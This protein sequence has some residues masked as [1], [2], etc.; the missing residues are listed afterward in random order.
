MTSETTEYK[1]SAESELR[2][3]VEEETVVCELKS[4]LAEMFGTEL[5]KGHKYSFRSGSKVAVFTYHGCVVDLTG[6]PEVAYVSKE[7]PMTFYV[8]L[9]AALEQL[10]ARAQEEDRRGPV[11]MIV[12]PSDCGKSTLCRILLNYA[13]RMGRSPMF[14]DLDVGQGSVSIAGTIGAVTVERPADIEDGF[15]LVAP[16]VYHFG[17]SSPGEN[18]TLY[19]ILIKT[20]SESVGLKLETEKKTKYS[21]I[22]INTCGWVKSEGYQSIVKASKDFGVDIIAVLDQ[23]RLYNELVRDVADSVRVCLSC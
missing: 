2:F 19:N 18:I 14:V 15:S 4:G 16:I 13:V 7:T 8:N 10:R 22:V 21:G 23:E 6:K 11:V 17:H 3:E 9:S 1:L 12:G 20:L 5:S